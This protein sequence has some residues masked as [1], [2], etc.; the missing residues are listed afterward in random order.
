VAIPAQRIGFE[1]AK[2][3]DGM[4]SGSRAAAKSVFLPPIRVVTRHSTSLFAID[5]PVV[6]GAL[7]YIRNHLSEPMKVSQIATNLVVRRRALEQK[8]RT[9]LGRSVLDEIHRVR[10]EKAKE[11]LAGTDLLVSQ[12]ARQSGFSTP[13]RMAAVFRKA[14]GVAPGDYRRQAR[15]DHQP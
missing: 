3:L 5:E 6:T 2:L 4:L 15:I 10:V 9:L 14:A 1:A 13:Q 11:L 8:F 7:H 12:V